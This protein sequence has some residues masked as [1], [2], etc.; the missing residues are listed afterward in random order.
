MNCPC[1]DHALGWLIETG[2]D[3]ALW[4]V[5]ALNRGKDRCLAA[6]LEE[7]AQEYEPRPGRGARDSTPH[8]T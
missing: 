3:L 7:L 8:G 5:R 6:R 2:T 4:L 1:T